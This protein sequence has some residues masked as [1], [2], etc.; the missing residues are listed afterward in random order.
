[1][2]IKKKMGSN[3]AEEDEWVQLPLS[4][5][6]S[7]STTTIQI[8]NAALNWKPSQSSLNLIYLPRGW[9]FS[10][11]F[12]L[13]DILFHQEEHPSFHLFHSSLCPDE[14]KD[15]YDH[16]FG[17][18]DQEVTS[19]IN[20]VSIE[21][22]LNMAM[23]KEAKTLEN[24]VFFLESFCI[25]GEEKSALYPGF[26]NLLKNKHATVFVLTPFIGLKQTLQYLDNCVFDFAFEPMFLQD[27]WMMR[28]SKGYKFRLVHSPEMN[29]MW[30]QSFI[31]RIGS[32]V[33][34]DEDDQLMMTLCIQFGI[35]LSSFCQAFK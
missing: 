1:M 34:Q 27:A 22:V 5:S 8:S 35:W 32:V 11:V 26:V 13:L 23:E 6:T 21:T 7:T 30:K 24:H 12:N 14:T 2:Q 20:R 3:P 18:T 25:H 9:S 29:S 4:T 10:L 28:A 17:M 19:R 33:P 15:M 31:K 16:R